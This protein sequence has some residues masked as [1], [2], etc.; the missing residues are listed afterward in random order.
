M[1]ASPDLTA[2]VRY[3]VLAV[4]MHAMT[5]VRVVDFLLACILARY[6][7]SVHVCTVHTMLECVD[8]PSLAGIVN[9]GTLVV[10]DGMPLVWLGKQ[11]CCGE[12][13]ARCYG[14]DLM[15][16]LFKE[17]I[18]HGVRHC[19][20]GS[21]E[22]VLTQLREKLLERFPDAQIV[23]AIAPP[24]RDLHPDEELEMIARI[25]SS[26]PDV[27]WVGLGTPK[28]D[29]WIGAMRRKLTVPVLIG[30]GAAFD[31]HAGAVRQAP[32]WMQRSG[33]EW[34][35]RLFQEPGRLWRRYLLGNPRFV[36]LFIR[37]ACRAGRTGRQACK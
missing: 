7:A 28:Q 12:H 24:F 25:E 32:Y 21:T 3:P 14:P 23:D 11:A 36:W 20:Y 5:P 15:L 10:P 18:P 34:L 1:T 13:V 27:V 26:R 33:L 31:F 9:D 37:S 16:L 30:V 8:D 17:G 35:F 22:H 6:P 2:L 19:L 4:Q 29:L